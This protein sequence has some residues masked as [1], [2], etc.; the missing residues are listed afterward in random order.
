MV[1]QADYRLVA[2]QS[3]ER[4]SD[5]SNGF[6]QAGMNAAVDDSVCLK[7]PLGDLQFG[8]NF[9]AGGPDKM[10]AHGPSPAADG[11]VE[12]GSKVSVGRGGEARSSGH[13]GQF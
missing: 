3:G 1:F 11:S 12:R 10:N 9:V 4:S 13:S 2:R 8:D 6:N 7:M 5:R